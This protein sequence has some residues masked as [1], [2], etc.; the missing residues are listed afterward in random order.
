MWEEFD[1]YMRVK[2]LS[3]DIGIRKMRELE[4]KHIKNE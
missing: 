1:K 3:G 4:R 2:Y